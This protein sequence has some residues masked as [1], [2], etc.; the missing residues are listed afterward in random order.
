MSI[1]YKDIIF[2]II[3]LIIGQVL[4]TAL[5]WLPLGQLGNE[6][7]ALL[8]LCSKKYKNNTKIKVRK[9]TRLQPTKEFKENKDVEVP[10]TNNYEMIVWHDAGIDWHH[11]NKG[12]T[13]A[14]VLHVTEEKDNSPVYKIC[15]LDISNE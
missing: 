2:L 8:N 13:R 3:G 4:A 5:Y 7:K 10:F 9:S 6:Y 11:T 1:E 12:W 14:R 15:H